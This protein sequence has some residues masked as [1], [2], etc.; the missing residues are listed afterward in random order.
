M[1]SDGLSASINGAT[2]VGHRARIHPTISVGSRAGIGNH[3]SVHRYPDFNPIGRALRGEII[4]HYRA[5]GEAIDDEAGL[6][7]LDTN[8]TLVPQRAELLL[9]LIGRFSG[10]GSIEGLDVADLGCGFGAISLYFANL[11]ARVT[12]VDPKSDR[13]EVGAEVASKLGL[14]ASFKRGW[15][16]EAP[17]PDAAFDIVVLNNSFCYLTERSDRSQALQ[18]ALRISRLGGG[19][20][21]R[22]PTLGSPVDPFT[23]LPLVHQLPSVIA[24]PVL[25]LARRGGTRSKVRLVSGA[26]ARR[27]LRRAGFAEVRLE[28]GLA[29]RRPGRYQHLTGRRPEQSETA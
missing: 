14:D 22:N 25:R 7:T 20:V 6:R 11:G 10:N 24:E 8:S 27:E 23:G 16:E 2:T 4:E 26:G 9:G 5:R 29:E 3:A 17:L 18:H 15:I 28:R 1:T 13:L 19:L 12:G 21:M